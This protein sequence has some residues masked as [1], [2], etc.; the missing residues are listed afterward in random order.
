MVTSIVSTYTGRKVR[1]RIAMTGETTLRGRV[2]PV[3]GIKEKIL[4][5][6]RAGITTLLLSEENRKDIEEIK[7][8]YIR[9]L[10]FHYVRT[11]DDVLQ[12]ALEPQRNN[13][14]SE[15]SRRRGLES[16][17]FGS[18]PFL[19]DMDS[20]KFLAVIPARYASTRFPAN[21]WH[22]SAANRSSGTSGSR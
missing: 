3:G 21:R 15:G 6:K 20:L 9:G 16:R 22:G 19:T 18:F 8:D 11:N 12:L 2:T 10:T 5:A 1:D 7:P 13:N 17:S 4:A 14:G